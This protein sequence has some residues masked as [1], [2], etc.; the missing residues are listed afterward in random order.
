MKAD[1]ALGDAVRDQFA[2]LAPAPGSPLAQA[3]DRACQIVEEHERTTELAW[4]QW[5]E[6]QRA[7]EDAQDENRR[8]MQQLTGTPTDDTQEDRDAA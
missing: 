7:L 4:S 3:I 1:D 6:D 8:L 2:L 5:L